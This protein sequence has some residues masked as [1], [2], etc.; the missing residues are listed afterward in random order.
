MLRARSQSWKFVL[1]KSPEN[2]ARY[3][4]IFFVWDILWGPFRCLASD[5][6]IQ[7]DASAVEQRKIGLSARIYVSYW[8]IQIIEALTEGFGS[9]AERT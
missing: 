9:F 6:V 3:F 1:K 2:C 7:N 8:T 5:G 4:A